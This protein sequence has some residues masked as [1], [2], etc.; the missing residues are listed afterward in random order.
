[1]SN[2]SRLEWMTTGDAPHEF[3]WERFGFAREVL[4]DWPYRSVAYVRKAGRLRFEIAFAESMAVAEV[5]LIDRPSE[6]TPIDRVREHHG[7]SEDEALAWFSIWLPELAEHASE[8]MRT[9]FAR[10]GERFRRK[11]PLDDH[12]GSAAVHEPTHSPGRRS[13]VA[14]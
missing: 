7:V 4:E 2:P 10:F 8:A 13:E 1:M 12:V 9:R 3:D 6:D 5:G 11:W 14:R